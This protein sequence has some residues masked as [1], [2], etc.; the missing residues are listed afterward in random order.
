MHAC[1]YA[2]PAG[3]ERVVLVAVEVEVGGDRE[4][5]WIGTVREVLVR[6]ASRRDACAPPL[7]N[8]SCRLGLIKSKQRV[9]FFRSNYMPFNFSTSSL[10]THFIQK[11]RKYYF[12]L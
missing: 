8:L 5:V 4:E 11:I 12:L 10:T 7:L 1:D 3:L 9:I 6:S 2:R